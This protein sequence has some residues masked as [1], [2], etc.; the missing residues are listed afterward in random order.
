MCNKLS[1]ENRELSSKT[2]INEISL[3]RSKLQAHWDANNKEMVII[4]T[5]WVD[6]GSGDVMPEFEVVDI[7]TTVRQFINS[8]F[9]K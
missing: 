8:S 1:I 2:I 6:A 3:V 5:W 7:Y 9:F 4:E